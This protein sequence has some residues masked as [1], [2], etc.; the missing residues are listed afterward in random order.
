MQ[1]MASSCFRF[2]YH[3]QTHT[4]VGRIPLDKWFGSLQR[5]L[6]WIY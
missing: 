1:A 3:K 2:L 5:P 4:T 6:P